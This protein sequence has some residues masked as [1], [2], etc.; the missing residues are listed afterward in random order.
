MKDILDLKDMEITG[1]ISVERTEDPL[2][3]LIRSLM[4][5]HR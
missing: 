4:S 2:F 5:W 3:L 1:M